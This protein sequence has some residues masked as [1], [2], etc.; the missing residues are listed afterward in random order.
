MK[1]FLAFGLVLLLMVASC[2]ALGPV[3]SALDRVV[4]DSGQALKII[5]TTYN[6]YQADHPLPPAERA[7]F[8]RLLANAYQQLRTGTRALQ[9]AHDVD[10]GKYDAAFEDFKIAYAALHDFLKQHGVSPIGDGLVGAGVGAD[11]TPPAA[12][13]YRVR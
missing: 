7:T 11:F 6:V 4:N 5:E 3:L 9:D 13:G 2:H 1:K 10:Q 8:D 12:I